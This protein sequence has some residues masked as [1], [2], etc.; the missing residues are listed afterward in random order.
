MLHQI[1]AV[2]DDFGRVLQAA[3]SNNR[4]ALNA[5]ASAGWADIAKIHTVDSQ[6]IDADIAAYYAPL[7]DVYFAD[8]ARARAS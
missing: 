1:Q 4:T 6:R 3:L 7:V 2:D 5:A 8:V